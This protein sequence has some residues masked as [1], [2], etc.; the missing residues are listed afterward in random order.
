MKAGCEAVLM[1]CYLLLSLMPIEETGKTRIRTDCLNFNVSQAYRLKNKFQ[2]EEKAIGIILDL[3]AV[4][5]CT[6]FS[7]LITNVGLL[8]QLMRDII[9]GV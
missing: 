7:S 2:I 3:A 9:N 1:Q 4:E 6:K 5:G 8:L